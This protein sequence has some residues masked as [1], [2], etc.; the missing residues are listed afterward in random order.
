MAGMAAKVLAQF[1]ESM[2]TAPREV[3][4]NTV[5]IGWNF[6]GGSIDIVFSFDDEDRHVSIQGYN[7]VKGVPEDK[8]DALYKEINDCNAQY[9]HI[10]FYL[11]RSVGQIL[12]RDEDVIQL[13]TCGP[14]CYELMVRMVK[15]VEDA[16]PKFMKAMWA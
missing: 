7:F 16:Y 14:E 15:I 9:V 8:Y 2:E 11:D 13:D 12:A 1:M 4:E 3:G 5:E 10:K 6:D